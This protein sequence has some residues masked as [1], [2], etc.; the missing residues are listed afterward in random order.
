MYT[1][2]VGRKVVTRGVGPMDEKGNSDLEEITSSYKP[3]EGTAGERLAVYNAVDE[4]DLARRYYYDLPE[5]KHDVSIKMVD[6]EKVKYGQPYK[7]RITLEV[8]MKAVILYSVMT[9][10]NHSTYITMKR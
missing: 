9:P 4:V 7:V 1:Y 2:S 5:D 3:E 8:H 10:Y 6:L